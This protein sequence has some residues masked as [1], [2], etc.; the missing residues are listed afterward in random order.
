MEI[1][2]QWDGVVYPIANPGTWEEVVQTAKKFEGLIPGDDFYVNYKDEEDDVIKVSGKE[3]LAEALAWATER[4]LPLCLNIPYPSPYSD[5]E[6]NWDVISDVAES[7][8]KSEWVDETEAAAVAP[9]P[10]QDANEVAEAQ[11]KLEAIKAQEVEEREREEAEAMR[12]AQAIADA[13][14][15]AEEEECRRKA[16]EE[17]ELAIQEA[18]ETERKLQEAQ[19]AR[20]DSLVA[21]L[22]H[23]LIK[24]NSESDIVTDK[25]ELCQA[26]NKVMSSNEGVTALKMM[27][28]DDQLLSAML[29]VVAQELEVPGSS[30]RLA[31]SQALV[32]CRG[33]AKSLVEYPNIREFIVAAMRYLNST[34]APEP[35]REEPVQAK[36]EH[37][38]VKC[39]GCE[40]PEKK[41]K[42]IAMGC[43]G[44]AGTILGARYKSAAI[45]DFDLCES[46]EACGEFQESHG[47]FLKLTTSDNAP[48][49]I[50]LISAD[51]AV[52][53]DKEN[54][55][56]RK[57]EEFLA[58]AAKAPEQPQTSVP[59]PT[60]EPSVPV[61]QESERRCKHTLVTFET[62]HQ[63]FV[64]DICRT[65]QPLKSTVHGCRICDFDVCAPCNRIV[66]FPVQAPQVSQQPPQAK[67]VSDGTLADGS[68]LRPGESADKVWRIRNSG[69]EPWKE[70]T[71]LCHVGGEA[72]GGPLEGVPVPLAS[73]GEAVNVSVPLVMPT[74]PGRYTSYWRMMTPAPQQTKFG[75][76]F[77]VTVNVVAPAPPPPPPRALTIPT[78]FGSVPSSYEGRVVAAPAVNTAVQTSEFE[79]A[80]ARITE[81]GFTDVEKIVRVLREVDGDTGKAIDKLLEE[82]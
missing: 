4:N 11:A 59:A 8:P 49:A 61:P 15:A 45:P 64:C 14:Q 57:F 74:Q 5:D 34:P 22:E 18:L 77:W 2:L 71:R 3:S 40:N 24:I 29:S 67:F 76:R 35:I 30:G 20:E 56:V 63:G 37:R 60:V 79:E 10:V 78:S 48:E 28:Q 73:P 47:P 69:A 12:R 1:S 32:H 31:L 27:V 81:F 80:V 50:L 62:P 23:A 39:D 75:H 13:T 51:G 36:P 52:T 33:F 46:C 25:T 9:E 26:F 43:R 68:V 38:L 16:A 54:E 70:G 44:A 19:Q 21:A 17:A 58:E 65:R 6:S 53:G 72:L 7:A 55:Y 42:A 82:N 41:E 66:G